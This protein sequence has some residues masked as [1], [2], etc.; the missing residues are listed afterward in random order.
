MI[1]LSERMLPILRKFGEDV[2]FPIAHYETSLCKAWLSMKADN[3][4]DDYSQDATICFELAPDMDEF[5]HPLKSYALNTCLSIGLLMEF[6]AQ[7]DDSSILEV[8]KLAYENVFMHVQ[9]ILELE[10]VTK[11]TLTDIENHSSVQFELARM[12]TQIDFLDSLPE[13]VT[14]DAL[15]ALKSYVLAMPPSPGS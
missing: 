10:F 14:E 6:I 15:K 3:A 11:R 2:N 9:E 5:D 13:Q 4:I 8:A 1:L 12:K 7:S